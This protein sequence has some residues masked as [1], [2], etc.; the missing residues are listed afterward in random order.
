MLVTG[1]WIL[2]PGYWI[3]DPGG[4]I[5]APP[6]AAPGFKIDGFVKSPKFTFSVIPAKAG[7]Q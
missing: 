6:L 2:G 3:L 5:S 4:W 7:I 1:G